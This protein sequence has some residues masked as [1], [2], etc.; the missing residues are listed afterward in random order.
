VKLAAELVS[1][2]V[3]ITLLRYFDTEAAK[4]LAF[5]IEVVN[6]WFDVMNSFNLN[7][8]Q[9]LKKPLGTHFDEQIDALNKTS[10]LMDTMRCFDGK[11]GKIKCVQP[12]QKALVFSI[13]ATK[14]L[15]DEMKNKFGIN[16]IMTAKLNNDGLENLFSQIKT[17]GVLNDCPSPADFLN[18]LKLII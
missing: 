2:T 13:K 8:S 1:H 9:K 6:D 18:R 5:T 10:H 16:F 12:F 4:K 15:F 7:A 14:M 3:S 11:K 17:K